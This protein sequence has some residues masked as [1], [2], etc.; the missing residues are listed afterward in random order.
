MKSALVCGSLQRTGQNLFVPFSTLVSYSQTP[1]L[2]AAP[3]F[4]FSHIPQ[5]KITYLVI[6]VSQVCSGAPLYDLHYLKPLMPD[7]VCIYIDK[8]QLLSW[9][10]EI[11]FDEIYAA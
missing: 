8:F 6:T 4:P 10:K 11:S 3:L 1:G 7:V 2:F 5:I 9:E